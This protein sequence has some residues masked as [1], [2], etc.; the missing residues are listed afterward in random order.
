VV[1]HNVDVFINEGTPNN[2][3]GGTIGAVCRGLDHSEGPKGVIRDL[4]SNESANILS[5]NNFD[6]I[7]VHREDDTSAQLKKHIISPHLR[8]QVFEGNSPQAGSA[9][10]SSLSKTLKCPLQ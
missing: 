5:S 7:F 9:S 6:D 4:L 10:A 1:Y 2:I 3:L 8:R